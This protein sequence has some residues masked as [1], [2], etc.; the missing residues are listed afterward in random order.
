MAQVTITLAVSAMVLD[1]ESLLW[2]YGNGIEGEGNDKAV[3][4]VKSDGGS[5]AVDAHVLEA[6]CVGRVN[7]VVEML[8]DFSPA[9]AE[10]SGTYT[11]GLTMSDRWG[12]ET[13][14]AK[15]ATLTAAMKKY[16][17]DGMMSDWLNV[18]APSEASVYTNKL[19]GD[20]R[21]IRNNIY[22][23]NKPAI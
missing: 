6:S 23:L 7:E 4:N 21:E 5:K 2:K 10:S 3:N 18:T 14:T 9:V 15:T 22:T 17:L 12:G 13:P 8:Y 11:I 1:A 20:A 19:A 16:I